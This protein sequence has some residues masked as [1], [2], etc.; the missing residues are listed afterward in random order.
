M[1][2]RSC[3]SETSA[4]N[5]SAGKDSSAQGTAAGSGSGAAGR[6]GN[7]AWCSTDDPAVTAVDNT[8]DATPTA[9]SR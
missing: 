8:I 2:E 1:T 3:W 9:P 7:T 4:G 5:G 6:T